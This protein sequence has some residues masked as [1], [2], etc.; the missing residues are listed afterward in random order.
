MRLAETTYYEATSRKT[1]ESHNIFTNKRRKPFADN[2]SSKGSNWRIAI[3]IQRNCT[4]RY[5]R[6]KEEKEWTKHKVDVYT[7][8][9]ESIIDRI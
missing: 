4:N 9:F 5:Y 7:S 1:A 3:K 8:V 6:E 2:R